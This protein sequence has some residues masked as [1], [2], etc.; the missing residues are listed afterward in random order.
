MHIRFFKTNIKSDISKDTTYH[1]EMWRTMLLLTHVEGVNISSFV[2]SGTSMTVPKEQ[3]PKDLFRSAT[4]VTLVGLMQYGLAKS[5]L[6]AIN[7][8]T[9][10]HLCLDMIQDTRVGLAGWG[11]MPEDRDEDGEIVFISGLL[12]TL[13]GRCAALRTLRLRGTGQSEGYDAWLMAAQEAAYVEWA[14]FICSVQATLEK[15][16]FGRV[17]SLPICYTLE[18]I[19]MI[20]DLDERFQWLILPVILSG[21]WACLTYIALRGVTGSNGQY[22]TT[23]LTTELRAILGG[24]VE[25]VV[26]E[27][28][29]H[30]NE[31][32]KQSDGNRTG[33]LKCYRRPRS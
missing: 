21:N 4:S 9:I 8:A 27:G 17:K 23:P 15:F 7:P 29:R 14:S 5:V 19:P 10:K 28:V 26:E 6:N 33:K 12:A 24:N 32:R 25:I 31:P 22:G 18:G 2:C 16:T 3:F 13:T 11:I 20:K 1:K 30:L